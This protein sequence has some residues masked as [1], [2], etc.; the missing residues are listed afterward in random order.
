MRDDPA[1]YRSNVISALSK[2][3]SPKQILN[4]KEPGATAQ[5]FKRKGRRV[6]TLTCYKVEPR[7]EDAYASMVDTALLVLI[8]VLR[9]F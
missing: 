2:C 7:F 8:P 3:I 5:P 6:A 1:R 4:I 9:C